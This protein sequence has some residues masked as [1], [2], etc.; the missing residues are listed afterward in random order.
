M[1]CDSI[2]QQVD[3][4]AVEQCRN[5]GCNKTGVNIFL[6]TVCSRVVGLLANTG[7]SMAAELL[8]GKFG[9]L[10]P[11]SQELLPNR[12][13]DSAALPALVIQSQVWQLF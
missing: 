7:R 9:H 1:L 13:I 6:H 5:G 4:L 3:V 11:S 2:L 8:K 10:H 12:S